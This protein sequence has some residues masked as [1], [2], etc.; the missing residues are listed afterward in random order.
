[1]RHRDPFVAAM[2]WPVD[3]LASAGV[4]YSLALAAWPPPGF[5]W[6]SI[7]WGA[8]VGWIIC[9]VSFAISGHPQARRWA[10]LCGLL[11]GGFTWMPMLEPPTMAPLFR[12]FFLLALRLA[13]RLPVG[14]A[15]VFG[16]LVAGVA[17][18][19]AGEAV[20]VVLMVAVLWSA[21]E[22]FRDYWRARWV[23]G[24]AAASTMIPAGFGAA[25]SFGFDPFIPGAVV[26]TV[27]VFALIIHASV[28]AASLAM[29]KEPPL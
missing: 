16:T 4:L 7:A 25:G 19:P 5:W 28:S 10:A 6:A 26:F 18:W 1:M 9:A 3:T 22:F 8:A 2:E 24:L 15:W 21:V 17:L 27:A 13:L 23:K 12:V 11:A 20:S 14:R 29:P